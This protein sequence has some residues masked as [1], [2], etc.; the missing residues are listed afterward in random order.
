[1]QNPAPRSERRVRTCSGKSAIVKTHLFLLLLGLQIEAERRNS[2]TSRHQNLRENP[3]GV[4]KTMSSTGT[5][6]P[7]FGSM[8]S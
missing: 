2:V 1:M 7:R 4:P 5:R 6:F 3:L 8:I